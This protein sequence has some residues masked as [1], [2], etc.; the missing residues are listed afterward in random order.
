MT[1][2]VEVEAGPIS[3][4]FAGKRQVLLFE[5]GCPH[6]TDGS[7]LRISVTHDFDAPGEA[8]RVT[9]EHLEKAARRTLS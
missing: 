1:T 2:P 8:P 5:V 6:A 7:V 9:V 3:A 4:T